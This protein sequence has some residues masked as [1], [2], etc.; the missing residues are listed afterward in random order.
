MQDTASSENETSSSQNQIGPDPSSSSQNENQSKNRWKEG[1]EL[2][3]VR[4]RFPGNSRSFPFHVGKRDFR[5]GQKVVAMSDR[6]I[7]I[8]Y[9]NSFPY[10]TKFTKDLMPIRSISKSATN[11]DLLQQQESISKQKEAELLCADLVE[12]LELEMNIT[13]VE[14]IQFGKKM[15]FY[16]TAPARIDFR[17][18]V[19][20]LVAKLKMR[21]ELRQISV[22]DRVAALGSIGACGL[23]TCCSSFLKNYGHVSIKMAKN[24]N[25]A[26]IPSKLNGVC[27]Q[28][29]CCIK[30]ED[31][32]YTEKRKELPK[33]GEYLEAL[34]GDKGKVRKVHVLI[35]QFDMITVKG[36]IRRYAQNQYDQKLLLPRDFAFPQ[37]FDSIS[38]ELHT[39]IGINREEAFKSN[40]FLNDQ[41]E[42]ELA[43]ANL[44]ALDSESQF[45]DEFKENYGRLGEDTYFDHGQ[46]S[47]SKE[48]QDHQIKNSN[49]SHNR[50]EERKSSPENQSRKKSHH[51]KTRRPSEQQKNSSKNQG[52]HKHKKRNPRK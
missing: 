26:L 29:K 44:N 33:E 25:L 2:K 35:G 48:N 4:V 19:K 3:M 39:I 1:D 38:N 47:Q 14:S 6:G 30:Y 8:G 34:N 23:S 21:I 16:F 50:A 5:Y 11:E 17:E 12:K 37:E 27:G 52:S 42:R 41:N 24:Q 43:H 13:H 46:E 51:R 45:F 9:I 10:T 31:Q 7:D 36:Q 22:R 18:L 28:I 20:R 15:V 49:R 32:V 40:Q